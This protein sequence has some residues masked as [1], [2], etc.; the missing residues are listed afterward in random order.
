MSEIHCWR[1]LVSRSQFLGY[2][3]VVAPD[4]MCQANITSLLA[5][6]AE[7][8]LTYEN[9][10][11]YREI[12]GSK[13]GDLTLIYRIGEAQANYINAETEGL[14]K[15]SFGREIFFIEGIVVKGLQSSFSLSIEDLES[16]HYDLINDYREFWEWVSPQAAIASELNTIASATSDLKLDFLDLEPYI[17]DNKQKSTLTKAITPALEFKQNT[18]NLKVNQPSVEHQFDGEVNQCFWLSEIELI[19]YIRP[20]SHSPHDHKVSLFNTNTKYED[21]LIKGDLAIPFFR[22]GRSIERICLSS[23]RKS[24]IS[25]NRKLWGKDKS[26]NHLGKE[27]SLRPCFL[28]S[29]N[30]FD[31]SD[32]LI[33]EGGDELI[34]VSKDFKWLINANDSTFSPLFRP[35]LIDIKS[36][37]K[38]SMS[39]GGHTKKITCLSSSFYDNVF[40][41]GDESGFL[42]LWNCDTFDSIGGLPV[43][44]SS[45]I[46]AIVFNQCEKNLVCTGNNGEIK[47]VEYKNDVVTS[48]SKTRVG[49]HKNI[50]GQVV[51]V[52]DLAFSPNGKTFASAGDD[53][54][55]RIWEIS[56]NTDQDGQIL[57]GHNN[58]VMSLSFSPNGKLL[59]SGSKDKTVK[60]WQ[61]D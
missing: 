43:F 4:F 61:I 58:S 36:G 30:F 19:I 38:T 53:G 41:S 35:A 18:S 8:D 37:D 42:R 23:D 27:I 26:S 12:H 48:E 33:Y 44:D 59:A 25:S 47:I 39:S 46:D 29:F 24:I 28:N 22:S 9:N 5:K 7:G 52:N 11:Y 55:I 51:K 40:A 2:R 34:A 14:L 50:D 20:S 32:P 6:S 31:K 15:D 45:S 57:T 17:A 3:T 49:T 13:T 56:N 60:I 16:I 21:N 54:S 10:A 1:F